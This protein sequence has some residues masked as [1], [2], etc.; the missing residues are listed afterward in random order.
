MEKYEYEIQGKTL[1]M[2]KLTI[3]ASIRFDKVMSS[4]L[5]E[6]NF[7][8]LMGVIFQGQGADEIDWLEDPEGAELWMKIQKD[9]FF[10]QSRDFEWARNFS[11]KYVFT[12]TYK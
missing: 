10:R 1:R 11:E 2:K 12:Q 7:N 3:G 9:F 8:E 4:G 6:E 5:D